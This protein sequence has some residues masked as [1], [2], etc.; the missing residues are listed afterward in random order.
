[1]KKYPLI[2][3]VFAIVFTSCTPGVRQDHVD[4]NEK[5][6][7]ELA[8]ELEKSLFEYILNVWYP[9][10]IDSNGGYISS[11]KHDWTLS[12]DSQRKALVQQARHLWTTS[13]VFEHYP[14][15]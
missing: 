9:R 1:M 11:F 2:V 8:D 13:Y 14:D 4:L 3:L 6:S 15:S 10:N 7:I 12:E 5:A